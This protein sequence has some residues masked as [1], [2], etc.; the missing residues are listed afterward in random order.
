LGLLFPGMQKE[1]EAA[2]RMKYGITPSSWSRRCMALTDSFEPFPAGY[3]VIGDSEET[4]AHLLAPV[5]LPVRPPKVGEVRRD[6]IYIIST[7]PNITVSK[8]FF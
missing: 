4:D 6:V 5:M 8:N 1:H 2:N 3:Q 7:A